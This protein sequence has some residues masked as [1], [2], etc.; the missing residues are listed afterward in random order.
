MDR[1]RDTSRSLLPGESISKYRGLA[2]PPVHRRSAVHQERLRH[3]DMQNPSTA[4]L[5]RRSPQLSRT[6]NRSFARDCELLPLRFVS[7]ADDAAAR[8]HEKQ[9]RVRPRLRWI[10][11]ANFTGRMPRARVLRVAPAPSSR[12]ICRGGRRDGSGSRA[13][14]RRAARRHAEPEAP[15]FA[16]AGYARRRNH[17]RRGSGH[18]SVTKNRPMKATKSLKKRRG[19]LVSPASRLASTRLPKCARRWMR[20]TCRLWP[21]RASR[22]AAG[23][24][25][26]KKTPKNWNSKKH[27]PKPRRCS[28]PKLRS[29]AHVDAR[30][31]VRAPAGT[32]G[33]TQRAPRPRPGFDRQRRRTPRTV[34]DAAS[35]AA[36]RTKFRRSATC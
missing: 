23:R 10:G 12:R 34:V 1:R 13:S 2:Q 25:R 27:R 16:A 35:R 26:A 31:E 14:D 30:A 36:S 15:A 33:Y 28:T 3:R 32:A 29:A 5:R 6:M 19:P 8:S 22:H 18:A 21:M 9:A 24:A 4:I 20:S 17:R 11:T 7:E